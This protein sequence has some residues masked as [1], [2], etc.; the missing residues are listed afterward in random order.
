M[1]KNTIAARSGKGKREKLTQ[2][3][4]ELLAELIEDELAAGKS[5]LAAYRA[6]AARF[7]A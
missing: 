4:I 2:Y 1:A 7:A 5:A 6:V 3:E